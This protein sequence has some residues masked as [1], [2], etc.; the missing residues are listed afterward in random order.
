MRV[1]LCVCVCLVSVVLFFGSLPAGRP[2]KHATCNSSSLKGEKPS[3]KRN[4][5]P[6][7]NGKSSCNDRKTVRPDRVLT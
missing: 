7:A 3:P 1:F 4:S 5:K 6:Q 2:T